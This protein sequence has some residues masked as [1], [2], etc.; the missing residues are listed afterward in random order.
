M[1][2]TEAPARPPGS[3]PRY[4]AIGLTGVLLDYCAFLLLFNVVDAH[5]QVANAVST[6][7]GITNNFVLN[8]AF[9]FRGRDRLPVRFARFYAVGIAGIL[10]TSA[11]LRVFSGVVGIDPNLVKVLSMPVVLVVQYTLNK[12]WSF[13]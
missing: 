5:E 6:T 12:K 9:N 1:R 10:L 13:A 3:L 7:A 8:A 11:A 2:G 4:A